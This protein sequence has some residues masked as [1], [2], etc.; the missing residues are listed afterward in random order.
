MAIDIGTGA[1]DLGGTG[2]QGYTYIDTAN[3][4]NASGIIASLELWFRADATGVKIGTFYGPTASDMSMRD[5]V[6]IGNVASGSKQTFS[7]LGLNVHLGDYLGCFFASGG[8]TFAASSG[9]AVLYYADDNF[10]T[11]THSY[12]TLTSYCFSMYGTGVETNVPACYL[13]AR[14][15]RMNMRGVSTQNQLA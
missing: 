13:H 3:P 12:S 11:G 2:T 14:R 15:D 10:H 8:M 6:T 7:V 4:A 1:T 5:F 9:V